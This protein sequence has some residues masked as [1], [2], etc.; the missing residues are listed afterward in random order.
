MHT[1]F[2]SLSYYL[3]PPGI[4]PTRQHTPESTNSTLAKYANRRSTLHLPRPASRLPSRPA[5][6]VV[7]QMSDFSYASARLQGDA[8]QYLLNHISA[9]PDPLDD[10][11][12]DID[13][14]FDGLAIIPAMSEAELFEFCTGYNVL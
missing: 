7:D 4:V 12:S 5:H 3:S 2:I 11:F 10:E 14:E 8:A 1:P 13:D 9:H 6:D